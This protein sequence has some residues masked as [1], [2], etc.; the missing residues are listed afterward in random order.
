L[1]TLAHFLLACVNCNSH[2]SNQLLER[3]ECLWLDVDGTFSALTYEAS[4]AVKAAF[5]E[6]T[7]GLVSLNPQ[8]VTHPAAS[9]CA[10]GFG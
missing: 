10:L 1:T 5:D 7:E 2:K 3:S 8:S 9:V 4:G 6:R